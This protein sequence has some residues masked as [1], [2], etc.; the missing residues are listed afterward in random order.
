MRPSEYSPISQNEFSQKA[1]QRSRPASLLS[2]RSLSAV[3]L[4]LSCAFASAQ[5]NW[6]ANPGFEAGTASWVNMPPWT[7]NGPSFG[8]QDTNQFVYTSTTKKVTVHGGTN[9]F[10][11]W[12]YFQSYATAPGAMQTF[13]ASPGSTWAASGWA[14]TQTPDNM[15]ST[16]TSYLEVQFL[17]ATT[18]IIAPLG[19]CKSDAL[20]TASPVDTWIQFQVVDPIS[21]ETNLTAPGGTAFVRFLVRFSQP[22]GYPGGSCYWD[23]VK[24]VLTSRPDP[25][26]TVQPQPVPSSPIY[27]QTVT[28]TV[29]A[30]GQTALSYLWQKDG[31][32]ISNPNAYGITT[33]TLTLSNANTSMNGAYT[34]TVTDSA[35]PLTSEAAVLSVQDP[36]VIS[37]TP[38]KGQTL[39]NGAT[40]HFSVVAAGSSPLSYQWQLN[41]NP[42]SN[43]GRTTGAL[44]SA[45]AIANV[46]AADAGTYTVQINGGVVQA[47][48]SLKVVS[49]AQ[50]ATNLL[51]N[52]GFEDGVFAEP[53]ET[54]WAPFNGAGLA[55]TNDYYYQSTTPVS[56]YDGNYVCRT[57]VAGADNGLYEN[58][59]PAAAGASYRVG[60]YFYVSGLDPV[61][62]PAWVVLQLFFKDS[63]GNNLATF[64]TPQIGPT[65][66]TN[67]WTFLQISNGT[68]GLDLVAPAGT[69]SATCQIYEYAQQGGGGSVYFD[70]LYVTRAS[71]PSPTPVTITPW[72]SGGAMHLA[73][74]STSGVTY[75][76]LYANSLT[77][78]ITWRTNATVAGDGTVK[79]VSDPLGS[80]QRYYRLLEH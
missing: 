31:A 54:A 60:G 63:A 13:R 42:L 59:V 48:S 72:I 78:P 38:P 34:V 23:D 46:T 43:G 71:L 69:A 26:I 74:P 49:P 35:G 19:D 68:G 1:P 47:S 62:A 80:A 56:V 5:T 21:L 22:A 52:P 77:N 11:I 51:V 4:A 39:T 50:L 65:F 2:L 32:P 6:L 67:T 7:W 40:A 53:W 15:T 37:I 24:L 61:V 20:T 70:D 44:S 18:N 64:A 76:V 14:A 75:E 33:A 36:G 12:G 30:D 9:A 25:E 41:G 73:F 27:G 16:D 8:Y 10:K 17:D 66:P 57:Y 58:N 29:V 55:T 3:I 28:F 45:L 79:T